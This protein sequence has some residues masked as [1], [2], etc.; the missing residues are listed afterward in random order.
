MQRLS[1]GCTAVIGCSQFDIGG[2]LF[3]QTGK[4]F[5][6]AIDHS[7]GVG[8]GLPLNSHD[9]RGNA[10]VTVEAVFVFDAVFQTGHIAKVNGLTVANGDDHTAK[11]LS[12]FELSFG[13][14]DQ[15]LRIAFDAPHRRIGV[16]I[17]Q[18]CGD[19][20]DGHASCS[21]LLRNDLGTNGKALGTVQI[22]LCHAVNGRE[23]G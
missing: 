19:V 15:Q 21:Q 14:N 12:V 6:D 9:H 23:R 5:V 3:A 1:N 4:L 18:A 20:F 8:G 22:D 10:V 17:S 13:L 2:H 11:F 16:G 7:H